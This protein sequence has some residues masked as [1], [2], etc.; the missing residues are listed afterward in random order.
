[1]VKPVV[2]YIDSLMAP[3]QFYTGGV[4]AAGSGCGTKVDHGILIVGWGNSALNGPFWIVMNS[5]GASWGIN[6]YMWISMNGT[7]NVGVCGINQYPS[8]P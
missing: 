8:Y 6:G 5:W 2:S 1:M 7:A 3:I 4:I